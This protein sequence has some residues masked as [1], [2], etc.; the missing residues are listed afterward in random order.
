[1]RYS[2]SGAFRIDFACSFWPAIAVPTIV[3][4]PEPITAPM[5]SEVRLSHPSD[6]LRRFSGLLASEMSWSMLLVRKSCGS[7]RHR[8]RATVENSTLAGPFVQP[9]VQN[10]PGRNLCVS[11]ASETSPFKSGWL[12]EL[13]IRVAL[14]QFLGPMVLEADGNPAVFAVAFDLDDG[15][16]AEFR[17]ADALAYEWVARCAAGW[18]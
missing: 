11:R 13:Q 15:A 10:M 18:E 7:N 2:S 9:V 3:K 8:P 4:I 14:E 6:F 17:M 5:P 1:M 16:D 12:G